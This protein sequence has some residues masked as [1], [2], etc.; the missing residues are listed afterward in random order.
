MNVMNYNEILYKLSSKWLCREIAWNVIVLGGNKQGGKLS[1]TNY[2]KTIY[3]ESIIQW[4]FSGWQLF[5][6]NYQ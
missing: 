6:G 3:L 5:G 2:V 1:G 4:Q